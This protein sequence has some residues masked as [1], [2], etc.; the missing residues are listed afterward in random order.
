MKAFFNLR[1]SRYGQLHTAMSKLKGVFIV[2][3]ADRKSSK[4]MILQSI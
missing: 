4:G 1:A 2:N 3:K